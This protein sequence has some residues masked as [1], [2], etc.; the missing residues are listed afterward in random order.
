MVAQ[1]SYGKPCRQSDGVSMHCGIGTSPFVPC[2][3]G[4]CGARIDWVAGSNPSFVFFPTSQPRVCGWDARGQS[5]F[6]E[7]FTNQTLYPGVTPT[8]SFTDCL[9]DGTPVE[10]G[11]ALT[12]TGVNS[13]A[14]GEVISQP[15]GISVTGAG[16]NSWG[17]ESGTVVRLR[18]N[19]D[20]KRARAVFSGACTATGEYGKKSTCD[21][22][23]VATQSVTVTYQCKPG[24]ACKQ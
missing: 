9:P 12:V 19:P 23:M 5:S 4:P 3:Y 16:N 17:Y 22:A 18:A 10:T 1:R 21:V 24:L 2:A 20:G 6:P 8:C 11:F 13:G 14:T 7:P 15:R